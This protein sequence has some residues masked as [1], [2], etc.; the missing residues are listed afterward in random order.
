M[1]GYNA[2]GVDRYWNEQADNQSDSSMSSTTGTRS[3]QFHVLPTGSP[4][5]SNVQILICGW[6]KG[7]EARVL[8]KVE[9]C[10]D[11][12]SGRALLDIG[13]GASLAFQPMRLQPLVW[14][15]SVYTDFRS[16]LKV[17][18]Q[19]RMEVGPESICER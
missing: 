1:L 10:K 14:M 4:F 7:A 12:E 11:T 2:R 19:Q 13:V 6:S 15:S 9:L 17:S 3:L 8:R 18:C 16:M 5:F